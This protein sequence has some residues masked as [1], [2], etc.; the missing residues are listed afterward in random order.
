MDQ[1][2]SFDSGQ[3]EQEIRN[4]EKL[5][6]V[7]QIAPLTRYN[8]FD[9]IFNLISTRCYFEQIKKGPECRPKTAYKRKNHRERLLAWH[10]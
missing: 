3:N 8:H 9:C 7:E 10:C 1:N 4:D 5:G 2:I 6:L